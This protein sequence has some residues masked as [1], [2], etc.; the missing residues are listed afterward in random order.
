MRLTNKINIALYI[1]RRKIFEFVRFDSFLFQFCLFLIYT[2]LYHISIFLGR[3]VEAI[4]FL[5]KIFR[6]INRDWSRKSANTKFLA[7]LAK[8]SSKRIGIKIRNGSLT[9]TDK[10]LCIRLKSDIATHNNFFDGRLIILS[11][12]DHK[13][14]GVMLIKFT[15]YFRYFA[16]IFD[17]EK[18]GKDYILI[19]EPSFSGYF[20]PDILS[21][22]SGDIITVIQAPEPVDSNFIKSINGNWYTVEL[23]S[24]CWVNPNLFYPLHNVEKKYDVIMVAIW[25]DFKRHWHLFES[26]SRCCNKEK[27]K[28]LLAGRS[29][30]R[31]LDEILDQAEYFN[32]RDNVYG[33]EDL[34]QNELNKYMNQSKICLLL[35]RKEGPNKSIIEAMYSNLPVFILDGFNYGFKYDYINSKTGGYIKR[36]Q[37]TDFLD[38]IDDILK[39]NSFAPNNW[40]KEHISPELSTHKLIQALER[41]E[42]ERG[43]EINKKLEVKYNKPELDYIDPNLWF[44][45]RK[46]YENLAEYLS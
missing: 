30:P 2:S 46:Y 15:D 31:K 29:W 9:Q 38:K 4:N 10:T 33:I 32:V 13:K 21:L 27:I 44:Q 19:T 18:I 22:L 37:L 23:G 25:S 28:V 43:I 35:S 17:L 20:D 16:S 14:K 34:S 45:M 1:Y 12:P 39:S 40:I 42:L 24:N 6:H 11:P 26:L 36:N 5:G 41:I 7:I 8:Y 3:N